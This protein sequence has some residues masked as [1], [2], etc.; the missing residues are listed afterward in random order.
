MS[1]AGNIQRMV[2]KQDAEFARNSAAYEAGVQNLA[3]D[4]HQAVREKL[5]FVAEHRE[6]LLTAFL[7]ETGLRP[8]EC[9]M[10]EQDCGGG[11]TEIRFERRH[12]ASQPTSEGTDDPA[13]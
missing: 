8:S 10:V 2:S 9:V 1:D 11:R 5:S 13:S 7:A 4:I 12:S 6:R 3:E